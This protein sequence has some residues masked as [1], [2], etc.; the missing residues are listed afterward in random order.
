MQDYCQFITQIRKAV[1]TLFY[2]QLKMRTALHVKASN[3]LENYIKS[4]NIQKLINRHT[5]CLQI[6]INIIHLLP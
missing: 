5:F 4:Q 1:K 2:R 3:I 6:T